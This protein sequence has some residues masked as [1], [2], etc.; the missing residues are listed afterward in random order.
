MRSSS[1]LLT[2]IF[3]A[4]AAPGFAIPLQG[5]ASSSIAARDTR[6]QYPSGQTR[7]DLA[8]A[9]VRRAK[10]GD[11]DAALAVREILDQSFSRRDV[12]DLMDDLMKRELGE[13]SYNEVFERED[14][15]L[16]SRELR[17]LVARNPEK[18]RTVLEVLQVPLNYL[19]PW[20]SKHKPKHDATHHRHDPNQHEHSHMPGQGHTQ[21]AVAATSSDPNLAVTPP[22]NDGLPSAP[23]SDSQGLTPPGTDTPPLTQDNLATPLQQPGGVDSSLSSG[24]QP[25]PAVDGSVATTPPPVKGSSPGAHTPHVK[26][27][28]SSSVAARELFSRNVDGEFR[29]R[30][31]LADLLRRVYDELNDLE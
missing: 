30:E 18:T 31:V 13:R 17:D 20:K 25:L 14:G 9:L 8:E 4:S 26:G 12:D 10:S 28:S 3:A 24:A 1:F 15:E 22:L 16:L 21:H 23:T 19:N 29:R 27:S 11:Q 2:I 5:E 6:S 7:R